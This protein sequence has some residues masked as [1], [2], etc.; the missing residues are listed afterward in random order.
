MIH[1]LRDK[2]RINRKKI[3][4]RNVVIIG[5]F[6]FISLSGALGFLGK[7]FNFIGRPIWKAQNTVVEGVSGMGYLIRTKSSVFKENESIK[8]EN[9]DLKLSMIDYDTLKK[10]NDSLKELL[11][12]LPQKE[13]FTLANILA[14]PNRSPYDTII[15]DIGKD[16]DVLEG[17][18]VFANS[19]IPIGEIGK[20]YANNSLVI[21]YS[22][23]GQTTDAMLEG[24]NANVE[25]VGRGG[26]N[27]EMTVPNELATDNGLTVVLPSSK[28][29]VI[30]VI[31]GIISRPTDP[32]KKVILHSPVNIQSLKWVQ[33]KRN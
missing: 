15:I 29:E 16:L 24:S 1:Q 4:T 25:L 18:K 11:G 20:V 10:E 22:N 13:N 32:V 23:P 3:I 7:L 9:A 2:K 5:L 17:E 6:L 26:G 30:A 21:L 27:F 33:I 19:N 8:K 12:R 28:S 14:K 31:D